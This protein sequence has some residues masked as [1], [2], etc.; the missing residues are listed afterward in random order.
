MFTENEIN[1]G[2]RTEAPRDSR[3][4][5]RKRTKALEGPAPTTAHKTNDWAK[6]TP[7]NVAECTADGV[8]DDL[9][10]LNH[11]EVWQQS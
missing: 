11:L 5:K 3:T 10:G 4:K 2:I 1:T 6:C 8:D 7:E 9:Y